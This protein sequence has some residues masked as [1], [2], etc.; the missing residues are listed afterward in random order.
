MIFKLVEGKYNK[1]FIKFEFNNDPH[2]LEIESFIK[3]LLYR[4]EYKPFMQGFNKNIS[5][6]YLYQNYYFP[7]QFWSEVK[8]KL[9]IKFPFLKTPILEDDG[10]N[11]L[12]YK[13]SE[14]E[15][16]N[17]LLNL[18]IPDS[19]SLKEE[20]AYQRDS[21]FKALQNKMGFIEVA[22]SG[23]KTFITYLYCRF[24]VE[25]F[26]SNNLSDYN[27]EKSKWKILIV[28][29]N[30]SLCIQLQNDF[31][32]YQT[33]E[34]FKLLTTTIYA[35]SKKYNDAHIVCGTFQSLSNYEQEY[36]DDFKVF[37]CDELHRAKAYTIQ[38]NI[39]SKLHN[40]E[41]IFGMSGTI[42][43][44]NTL[45]YINI[46]S[47]F[48]QKLLV[49]TTKQIIDDQLATPVQIE[50]IKIE[51]NEDANYSEDLKA[52]GIV[53]IEKYREEKRFFQ[54][55]RERNR[56]I[57][58]IL[59]AYKGS[60]LILVDTIDYVDLLE[61]LLIEEIKGRN[62]SKIYGQIK[63]REVIFDKMRQNDDDIIIA[64]Y[65]TMSTGISIKNLEYIMFVDGGKS[66]IRIR[67]SIGRGLRISP[68][69]DLCI[70]FDFQDYLKGSAFLNH[71]RARNQIYKEQN[72][73][74]NI[75]KVII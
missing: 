16:D 4:K 72:M 58:K 38:Q 6:S 7:V 2:D 61:N 27:P 66:E 50:V 60:T 1:N 36:F 10:D 47:I 8:E 45:D 56:L 64:T 23:G 75:T 53:G 63:D 24:L 43:K 52:N 44:Y 12:M 48:G 41:F 3:S 57:I 5:V 70:V 42:P 68:K 51:Y 22:T 19:I 54:H 71:A 59:K 37:I 14:D 67:Q 33:K 13:L 46:L 21:V 28:V 11:K 18:N 34:N 40:V 31:E 20:Y 9:P 62:I 74:V 39:Y 17:W 49:K 32:E 55:Y 26:F 73:P 69:K 15:F 35:G 65:G 25:N 30:K 29:P